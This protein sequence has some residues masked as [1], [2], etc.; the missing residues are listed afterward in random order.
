MQIG[1]A[2]AGSLLRNQL[3]SHAEGGT[4]T[5]AS[6]IQTKTKS[7]IRISRCARFNKYDLNLQNLL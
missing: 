5:H 4:G 3:A 1:A 7:K 2:L 6:P